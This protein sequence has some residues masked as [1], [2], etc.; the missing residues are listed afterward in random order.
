MK[1]G[2]LNLSGGAGNE[3]WFVSLSPG[4]FAWMSGAESS[5]RIGDLAISIYSP[6][7]SATD[8]N[9]G[10]SSLDSFFVVVYKCWWDRDSYN[11]NEG[12]ETI[13]KYLRL[14]GK[15]FPASELQIQVNNEFQP[16]R[17]RSLDKKWNWTF[18]SRSLPG[19]MWYS[20]Q[21]GSRSET[22]LLY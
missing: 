4:I 13:D 7:Y 5:F 12:D 22:R 10:I 11:R 21:S 15:R 18:I 8:T 9:D 1:V 14:L 17:N 6:F 2:C 3:W 20:H 19:H 16:T